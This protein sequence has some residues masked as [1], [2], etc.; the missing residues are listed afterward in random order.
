MTK[1]Q[2][3][4]QKWAQNLPKMH[5]PINLASGGEGLMKPVG[6]APLSFKQKYLSNPLN[7]Q[8]LS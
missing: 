4:S 7:G 6:F 2:G 5:L 8:D 3:P 1:P